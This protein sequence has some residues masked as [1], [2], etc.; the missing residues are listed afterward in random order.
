MPLAA[1]WRELGNRLLNRIAQRPARFF[2]VWSLWLSGLYFLLGPASYVRVIDAGNGSLP[3]RMW[4]GEQIWHGGLGDWFPLACCG[5]DRVL[6]AYRLELPNL[7][8][9]VLPGWLAYGAVMYL[10]RFV[11]G[12]FFFRLLRDNAQIAVGG[13]FAAGL[14]YS[15]YYQPGIHYQWD[16]FQIYEGLGLPAIPLLLWSLH[17]LHE[18]RSKLRYVWAAAG[19]IALALSANYFQTI[20]FPLVAIFWLTC[21]CRV[22]DRKM[23]GLLAAMGLAW[24]ALLAP[25]I[26]A[27][28]EF[29]PLSH[30]SDMLIASKS[31]YVRFIENVT[32]WPRLV[33]ESN[34]TLVVIGAVGLIMSRFRERRLL[35]TAVALGAILLFVRKYY[36]FVDHVF[37]HLG[38][39]SA[40]HFHRL[41]ILT[42]FLISLAMGLSIHALSDRWQLTA[43]QGARQWSIGADTVALCVVLANLA[44]VSATVNRDRFKNMVNGESYELLYRH[45]DVEAIAAKKAELPPF[46]VASVTD[47]WREGLG[48]KE[49]NRWTFAP[50]YAWAYGLETADGYLVLYSH[51]YKKFWSQV[52]ASLLTTD[53]WI[54]YKQEIWGN[55][56]YLWKPTDQKTDI[57]L[58][59][60]D[61]YNLDLLSLANVRFIFS[62]VP[63]ED[64]RLKLLPSQTRAELFTRENRKRFACLS[65]MLNGEWPWEPLYV[66]E[67]SEVLPR[68]FFVGSVQVCDGEDATLAALGH[69][70]AR[71]FLTRAILDRHDLK[72]IAVESFRGDHGEVRLISQTSDDLE[73][74]V[75]CDGPGMIVV[76]NTYSSNWRAT[77]DSHPAEVLPANYT[78]QGVPVEQGS[79]RVHLQ[80]RGADRWASIREAWPT[81]RRTAT[82]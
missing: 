16:G 38:P 20:F 63:L 51:R 57:P 52:L 73:L 31:Q 75:H 76:A 50:G 3:A 4:A 1:D 70:K 18:M 23:F 10:Q 58:T 29:A 24:A 13:A 72:D 81:K 28:A 49:A 45:P 74:E 69:T 39:L 55:M 37:A 21:I 43:A 36:F 7:L 42:P 60:W 65:G 41:V 44:L 61:T 11:A 59:F 62:P 34:L 82:K 12:Y 54:N 15:L 78:F 8:F 17:R 47:C 64:P 5:S 79:H 80:Y 77:V 9:A 27:A 66:Y 68:Y 40:F 19:G 22:L 32:Y 46:R 2:A 35:W 48:I 71:D 30:R 56:V 67:N 33:L 14:A 26:L 25:E 6:N 53:A